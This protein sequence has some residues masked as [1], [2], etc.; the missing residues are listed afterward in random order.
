[1]PAFIHAGATVLRKQIIVGGLGGSVPLEGGIMRDRYFVVS[2]FDGVKT[3]HVVVDGPV[4]G[5][6]IDPRQIVIEF[7]DRSRAETHAAMLNG[8]GV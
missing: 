1:M 6:A 4:A 7:R 8:R 2:R 3:W 5:R